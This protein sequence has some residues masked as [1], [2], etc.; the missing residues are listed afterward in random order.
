MTEI[1]PNLAGS[2]VLTAVDQLRRTDTSHIRLLEEVM[3]WP[4]R[5]GRLLQ[6][7]DLVAQLGSCVPCMSAGRAEYR[8]DVDR[9]ISRS[10]RQNRIPQPLTR[11]EIYY[12]IIDVRLG[13]HL[14]GLTGH[15]E[16][17]NHVPD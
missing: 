9:R 17:N 2:M 1:Y 14:A 7:A 16:G 5:A 10:G 12:L 13:D 8:E 15:R 3:S 11:P 6:L 4:G